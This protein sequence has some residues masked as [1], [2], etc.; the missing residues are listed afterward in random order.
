MP[1][2]FDS[3]SAQATPALPTPTA[4]DSL[5][6]SWRPVA[7]W[8]DVHWGDIGIAAVGTALLFALLYGL[9]MLARRRKVRLAPDITLTDVFLRA[10][11]RTRTLPLLVVT[12]CLTIPYTNPPPTVRG[13]LGVLL[14]ATLALQGAAWLR[15][16]L[17]G[18]IQ[19]RAAEQG[20]ETLVNGMAV[21]R[22]L[23]SVALFAIAAIIILSNMGVNVSGL[24]AGLGI[25]GIA[26]GLAAQ[27]IFADLFA[28][29]S[30]IFDRP[31]S[32]GETI[33]YDQTTATVER[34]GLKSTRLRSLNGEQLI[35]SNTNLLG[36][37]IANFARIDHRRV[38]FTL[39][40]VYQT[41]PEKLRALPDMLEAQVTQ[42]EEFG[43]QLHI[44]RAGFVAFAP[45][46][47]DFELVFDVMSDDLDLFIKARTHIAIKL[48]EAL[49]ANGYET[50]YPTQTTYTAAP[51][52]TLILPYFDPDAGAQTVPP[53]GPARS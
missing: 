50:A 25:G 40:L 52:G 1:I 23:I 26:I 4:W 33:R 9:R 30:I 37:E 41:P 3:S 32:N 13:F 20:S 51:D 14:T 36:K 43:S 28:A 31:F 46:S 8:F 49:A 53:S 19:R 44:T 48:I 2:L 35:I 10:A 18:V 16:I 42:D 24:L 5:M 15:D 47:L 21:I 6:A 7:A 34:I 12:L 39:S 29:L 45:S 11:G 17:L 27:G 22:L 38:T